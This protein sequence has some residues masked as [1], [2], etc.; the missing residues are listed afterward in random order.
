MQMLLT[1]RFD[2]E[3]W[4]NGGNATAQTMTLEYGIDTDYT[5]H[6]PVAR[7]HAGN[8]P[9]ALTALGALYAT[10][11]LVISLAGDRIVVSPAAGA[12]VPPS[13]AVQ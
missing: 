11:G 3:Q 7:L 2:G 4:R 12:T 10:Q 8:L 9:E 5:L 13:G 1:L 6:A